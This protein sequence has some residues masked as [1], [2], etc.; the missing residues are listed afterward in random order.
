MLCWAH[1]LHTLLLLAT[2]SRRETEKNGEK[3]GWRER[4]RETARKRQV[5][6]ETQREIGR[7][8][9][10]EV[11]DTERERLRNLGTQV[12]VKTRRDRK[13]RDPER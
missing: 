1:W 3:L 11:R 8:E 12:E 6:I 13:D 4:P 10:K 5:E 2:G 9:R 7:S